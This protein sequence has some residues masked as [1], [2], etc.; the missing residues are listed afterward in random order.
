LFSF[1]LSASDDT[2]ITPVGKECEAKEV[3][4]MDAEMDA[5]RTG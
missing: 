3:E 4:K 5:I 1:V 2:F